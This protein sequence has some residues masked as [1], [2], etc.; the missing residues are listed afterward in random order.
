MRL[1]HSM[2]VGTHIAVE[3]TLFGLISTPPIHMFLATKAPYTR[4]T[5]TKGGAPRRL[6]GEVPSCQHLNCVHRIILPL[7][8]RLL[9]LMRVGTRILVEVTLL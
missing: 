1:L 4:V 3:V 7:S 6:S 8:M 2:L 9:H 5:S